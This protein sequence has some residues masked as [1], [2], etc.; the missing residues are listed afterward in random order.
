MKKT[1]LHL[2]LLRHVIISFCL[3]GAIALALF[4]FSAFIITQQMLPRGTYTFFS[5]FSLAV[6]AFIGGLIL[7]FL[8]KR[9]GLLFGT[10]VGVIFALVI[11]FNSYCNSA[12]VFSL[13]TFA[14]TLLLLLSGAIGGYV[15]ILKSERR[16]KHH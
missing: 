16:K 5:L 2:C 9:H 14:R 3:C 7:A 8:Q 1:N 6:S 12:Q 13:V 11:A 10:F 15:G 4:F